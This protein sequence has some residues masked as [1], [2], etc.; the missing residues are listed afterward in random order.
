[1]IPTPAALAL[2]FAVSCVGAVLAALFVLAVVLAWNWAWA[3]LFFP[4][5]KKV[6][7]GG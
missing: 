5:V 6:H 1:M 4:D 2:A 3:R 7:K